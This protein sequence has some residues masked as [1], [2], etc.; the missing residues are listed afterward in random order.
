MRRDLIQQAIIEEL[1]RWRMDNEYT[2]RTAAA[3]LGVDHG[4]LSKIENGKRQPSEKFIGRIV[5]VLDIN[6]QRIY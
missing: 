6:P 4:L 3:L 1:Y 2:V 5:K